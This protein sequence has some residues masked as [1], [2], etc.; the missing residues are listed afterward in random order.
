M[1]AL[2]S[3]RQKQRVKNAGRPLRIARLNC[4]KGKHENL[5]TFLPFGGGP[6]S[7][8]I[9]RRHAFTVYLSQQINVGVA[10]GVG[11]SR[12]AFVYFTL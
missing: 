1:S 6:A 11:G 2:R 8:A 7:S 3:L 4:R 10:S 9:V 12:F 5:L